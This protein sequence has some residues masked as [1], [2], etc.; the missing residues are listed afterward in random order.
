MLSALSRSS[1]SFRLS[2]RYAARYF[3]INK[4]TKNEHLHILCEK[5]HSLN[6]PYETAVF[7]NSTTHFI[8][9]MSSNPSTIDLQALGNNF[10]KRVPTMEVMHITY[11]Y[12]HE[13]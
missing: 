8:R 11:K 13:E 4:Q 10:V 9:T 7:D 12:F 5:V 2:Q 6:P 3:T 1:F